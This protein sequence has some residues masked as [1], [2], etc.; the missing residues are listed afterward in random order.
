MI[1]ESDIY[2][3]QKEISDIK[4][5]ESLLPKS[6]RKFLELLIKRRLKRSSVWQVIISTAKPRSAVLP[7]TFGIGVEMDNLFGSGWLIDELLKLGFSVS[8]DEIKRYK[9]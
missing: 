5:N 2:P 6:L 9:Q 4:T 1:L 7:I 3:T 8:Y